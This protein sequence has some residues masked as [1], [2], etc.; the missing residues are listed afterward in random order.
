MVQSIFRMGVEGRRWLVKNQD[1]SI[2][3]KCPGDSNLLFF[4]SGYI[5]AVMVEILCQRKI[6]IIPWT[7]NSISE[8]AEVTRQNSFKYLGSSSFS[9]RTRMIFSFI[10]LI[11]EYR[12]REISISY[13]AFTTAEIVPAAAVTTKKTAAIVI[14]VFTLASPVSSAIK[15]LGVRIAAADKISVNT[16][17]KTK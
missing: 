5:N 10:L 12:K 4:S 13:P 6:R 3:V 11:K 8:V 14:T 7:P 9:Y 1:L 15:Y 17:F 16:M 2:F